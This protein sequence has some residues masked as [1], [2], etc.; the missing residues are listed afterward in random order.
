MIEE[1][2]K[3]SQYLH[4]ASDSE[5]P[6]ELKGVNIDVALAECYER[7]DAIRADSAE[8]RAVKVLSGLGFTEETMQTPTNLL[9]GGWTMRAALAAALYIQPDVLLLDEVPCITIC[10]LFIHLSLC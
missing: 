2:A 5:L 7:M 4:A 9:S 3:L 6:P 10:F 8:M 1:E